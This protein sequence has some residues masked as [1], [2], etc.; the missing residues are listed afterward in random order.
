MKWNFTGITLGAVWRYERDEHGVPITRCTISQ[1]SG[2]GWWDTI[3]ETVRLHAHD[4]N[5][6]RK[7]RQYAF[8]KAIRKRWPHW[9]EARRVAW[10]ALEDSGMRLT[11]TPNRQR[12]DPV[13]ESHDPAA[14]A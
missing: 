13:R 5:N 4:R 9:K 10:K 12:R 2:A 1:W 7:A 6:H 11:Y 3:V 8:H 14:G